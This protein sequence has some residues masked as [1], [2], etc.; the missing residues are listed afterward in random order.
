MVNLASRTFYHYIKGPYF[1]SNKNL[2]FSKYKS[3]LLFLSISNKI[4]S[5]NENLNIK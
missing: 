4:N 1:S 3:Q 5:I 2:S